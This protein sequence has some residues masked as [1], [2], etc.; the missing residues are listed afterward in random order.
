MIKR[1]CLAVPFF[2]LEMKAIILN[3]KLY[4]HISAFT[5]IEPEAY[6][7]SYDVED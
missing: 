6:S 3:R 2:S 4:V 1:D 7:Y 5:Y